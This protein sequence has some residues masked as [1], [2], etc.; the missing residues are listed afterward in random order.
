MLLPSKPPGKGQSKK[1][2]NYLNLP[3]RVKYS[4]SGLKYW[5]AKG[6]Q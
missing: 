2:N 1:E 5:E 4:V 3:D 6:R